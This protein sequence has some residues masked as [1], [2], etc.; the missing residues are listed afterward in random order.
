MYRFEKNDFLNKWYFFISDLIVMQIIFVLPYLM[1][2]WGSHYVHLQILF[3]LAQICILAIFESFKDVYSRGYLKEL[4]NV[5]LIQFVVF[6]AVLII[7]FFEGSFFMYSRKVILIMFAVSLFLIYFERIIVKNIFLK[8]FKDKNHP[9]YVLLISTQKDA[10][11]ILEKIKRNKYS[12]F[13]IV[14][15]GLIEQESDSCVGQ[16]I[17][18]VPVVAAGEKILEYIKN[19]AIDEVFLTDYSGDELSQKIILS[20]A[21]MGVV[22]H[23]TLEMPGLSYTKKTTEV[24]GGY[25]VLTCGTKFVSL[26]QVVSKRVFDILGSLLG[27]A[28]TGVLFIFVGPLIYA[29]S[30][31]P[32]FFSQERVGLNGRKFKIYKFRSMYMDAE[33]KKKNLLSENKMNGFMFKIDDDP[34][35]IKGIGSFIR[36]TSI[37]EFPQMW[38]VLKGEMSLVGTRPPTVDEFEKYDYHHK[39]RL[40]A[41][42]GITGLWQ[43]SGR[44]N[45]TD[46]EQV[47]ELDNTYIRE[48]SLSLDLK[49]LFRTVL[50]VLGKEGSV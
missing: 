30:P 47:V 36:K 11:S 41:K 7:L 34:R 40:A 13:T 9:R 50:V 39:S 33:E 27:L 21:D 29:K 2:E 12:N 44:S 23:Y 10:K 32:I 1:G 38:N 17:N 22:L 46:F 3:A 48:W 19:N 5:I 31:G 42:P 24:F 4:N 14:G 20:C 26:W 25:E 45:I 28:V 8:F 15:A 43:V 37:D 35:I 18:G 16:E 49:I 6:S